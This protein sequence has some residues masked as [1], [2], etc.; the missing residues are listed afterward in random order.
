MF[1]RDEG[2]EIRLGR[3]AFFYSAD[4]TIEPAKSLELVPIA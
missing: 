1:V 2:I 4:K 3:A